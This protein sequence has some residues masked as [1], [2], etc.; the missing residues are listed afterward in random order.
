MQNW[1]NSTL[2][3]AT[4]ISLSDTGYTNERLALEWLEHFINHTGSGPGK[5]WKILLMD[6]YISYETPEFTLRAA[7]AK[8]VC[9]VFPS[10]LTHIL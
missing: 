5:L 1:I 6:S 3:D 4:V 7:Q 8:I 10:Y 2:E 9:I